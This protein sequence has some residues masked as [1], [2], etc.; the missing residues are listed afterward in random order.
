[1]ENKNPT[2]NIDSNIASRLQ[3]QDDKIDSM[4]VISFGLIVVMFLGFLSLLWTV[5]AMRRDADQFSSQLFIDLIKET[6]ET[7]T[8]IEFLLQNK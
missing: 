5:E 8:K 3:T 1:M 6:K 7:N 2:G 4:Q